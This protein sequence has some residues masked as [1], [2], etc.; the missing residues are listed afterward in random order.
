MAFPIQATR[1]EIEHIIPLVKGGTGDESNLWLACPPAHFFAATVTNP[2]R[3][4]LLILKQNQLCR[5]S[6]PEYKPGATIS[7]GQMTG[8]K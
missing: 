8:L 7:A 2:A 3:V 4:K 6:I 5:C 1:L